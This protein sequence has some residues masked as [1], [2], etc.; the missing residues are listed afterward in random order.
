ML[1]A[2]ALVLFESSD[3]AAVLSDPVN[4]D[5]RAVVTAISGERYEELVRRYY[6]ALRHF[7]QQR[8]R[9]RLGDGIE[10]VAD[11]EKLA[12]LGMLEKIDQGKADRKKAASK[13][14]TAAVLL[15]VH[16][17]PADESLPEALGDFSKTPQSLTAILSGPGRPP[18]DG[19]CLLRAFLAAPLMGL[20]DDPTSVHRLLHNNPT[21]ARTCD[22]LGPGAMKQPWELTSRRL[23]SL[24]VCEEF[25][26]VMTRYALWYLARLGQVRENIALGAVEVEDTISFDTTHVEAN[27]HCANVVPPEAKA[28]AE[29]EGGKPKHRKVPR[30]RKR[31]DCGQE[32]WETCKHPWA[33]T[34]Q[35]AAVVVKGPTRVY[36]A[37]KTSLAAF[38]D[39][40]IPIDARACNYAAVGDGKTLL[41]HLALLERDLPEAVIELRHILADD[42]YRENRD[43]V[44]QFGQQAR[45][46][47]PVHG[48]KVRAAVA[49]AFDGIDRFTPTGVPICAEGHRFDL[50]GRDI[51]GERYIW[52]APN[53]G[54]HQPVCASCTQSGTCLRGGQRR[55]IRV[56]RRDLPQIDWDHPQHFTRNRARYGKRTGVERAIKRLKVD[57]N[58]QHLTH[59]DVHRVQAHLDRKLLILHLLLASAHSST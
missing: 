41:P 56:Q 48:R 47:V 36:W 15:D 45:L 21:F 54:D 28:K 27:S 49:E 59:R 10:V 17:D 39:S 5:W 19:L 40:E 30:V 22:F 23:P 25:S 52:V 14:E 51:P 12:L 46:T 2:S 11:G 55:H 53:D 6:V 16:P 18:C 29:Q 4:E 44:G 58:G 1:N 24:S 13:G 32:Q 35:G 31:C 26:E 43:A 38:G 20:G 37:H 33:P 50:L 7:R 8:S 34:D 42:P 57:L 3:S 9:P